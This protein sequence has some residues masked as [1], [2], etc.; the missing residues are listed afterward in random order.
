MEV[1][2]N[3]LKLKEFA[4]FLCANEKAPST[5]SKYIRDVKN[6]YAYCKKQRKDYITKELLVDYKKWLQR[7]RY[8]PS[9]I[10]SMIAA[11]N[12]YMDYNGSAD[13]L[14]P[15][16]I[17][18][19]PYRIN[20]NRLSREE[21]VR[22]IGEIKKYQDE[23]MELL[24]ET[25][26]TTGIRIGELKYFDVVS[27]KKRQI[28][29][30]NKGKIRRVYLSEVLSKKLLA[31]AEACGKTGNELI[32]STKGGK[33]LDRSNIWRNLKRYAKK[34]GL[35]E[36]KVYPHNFRHL[37]ATIHYKQYKDLLM[38]GTLLGHTNVETTRIYA[39]IDDEECKKSVNNLEI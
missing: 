17:Q 7:A 12:R 33:P 34:A 31:Y 38:L 27:I 3:E 39:A 15:L 32:F 21:Y 19:N 8:K 6:L 20:E 24:V 11:V 14:K 36:E 10:N 2:I 22:L 16:K 28:D 18:K 26:G 25:L 13:R 35:D 30:Q 1:E 9:S 5:I 29:V 4:Q 37:F 23:R